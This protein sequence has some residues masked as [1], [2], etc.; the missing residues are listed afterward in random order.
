MSTRMPYWAKLLVGTV[1]IVALFKWTPILDLLQLFVAIVVV[2]LAL[3]A[4][5]G[6]IGWGSIEA[7]QNV[8][9]DI[10]QKAKDKALAKV[11]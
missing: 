1:G 11:A 6:L 8:S 7:F 4:S 10:I 9:E 3:L 2:P 5:A